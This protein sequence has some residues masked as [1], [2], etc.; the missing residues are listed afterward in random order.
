MNEEEQARQGEEEREVFVPTSVIN[1]PA[2][3]AGQFARH[4]PN[5]GNLETNEDENCAPQPSC[6]QGDRVATSNSRRMGQHYA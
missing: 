1:V 5:R 6:D 3:L 2:L 4:E